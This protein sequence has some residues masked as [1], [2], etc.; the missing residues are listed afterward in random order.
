MK[1]VF[2]IVTVVYNGAILIDLTMQSVIN[3]SFTQYE[4]IVIDGLS[5]DGFLKKIMGFMMP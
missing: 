3:Q 5:K 4:Y 1:P 2:S